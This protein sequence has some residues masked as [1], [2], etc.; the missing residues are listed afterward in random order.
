MVLT[1]AAFSLPL[2]LLANALTVDFWICVTLV[3]VARLH[4]P[5]T[6]RIPGRYNHFFMHAHGGKHC[7]KAA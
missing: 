1:V 6:R 5:A 3:T 2:R 7:A 4:V